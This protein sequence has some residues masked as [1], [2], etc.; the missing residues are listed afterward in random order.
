MELRAGVFPPAIRRI[1]LV[2]QHIR[3]Q[4]AKA[5]TLNA[6]YLGGFLNQ[7]H[8]ACA[9]VGAVAGQAGWPSAR[10]LYSLVGQTAQFFQ[11]AGLRLGCATGRGRGE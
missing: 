10:P 3:V 1:S 5:D 7:F 4:A 2:V 9:A 11:H 6:R 8:Q